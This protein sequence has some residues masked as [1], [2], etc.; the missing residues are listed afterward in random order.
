MSVTLGARRGSCTARDRRASPAQPP[1]QP[2]VSALE[3]LTMSLDQSVNDVS[4]CSG[5]SIGRW[6]K[7]ILYGWCALSIDMGDSPRSLPST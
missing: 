3:A 4:G 1:R 7:N 5:R 6:P 2:P